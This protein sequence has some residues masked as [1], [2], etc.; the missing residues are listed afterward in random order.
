MRDFACGELHSLAVCNSGEVY[1]WGAGEYGQLGNDSRY[2]RKSPVRVH[3]S[4]DL[5]V[6]KLDAGKNHS[7]ILTDQGFLYCF[8]EDNLGQLGLRRQKKIVE[9]PTIVSYMTHKSVTNVACG[10]FHTVILIDPYYVF[11][12]GNNKY[13]QLGLGDASDKSTFTFVRKLA[14][15][16]VLDVF[17]GDH[18]S[19]FVLDH[20]D[21]FVDDYQMPE[22]WRFSE[23]SVSDDVDFKEGRLRNK[24]KQQEEAALINHFQEAG[25]R[26][27]PD[28]GQKQRRK[29]RDLDMDFGDEPPKRDKRMQMK[30]VEDAQVGGDEPEEVADLHD[31]KDWGGDSDGILES[32]PD[33][34]GEKLFDGEIEDMGQKNFY[35]TKKTFEHFSKDNS[36]V[37]EPPGLGVSKMSGSKQN[38]SGNMLGGPAP[39]KDFS[40]KPNMLGGQTGAVMDLSGNTHLVPRPDSRDRNMLAQNNSMRM[41]P[42]SKVDMKPG[43]GLNMM[44]SREGYNEMGI[45]SSGNQRVPGPLDESDP[46]DSELMSDKGTLMESVEGPNRL[47]YDTK[48]VYP[49]PNEPG[50]KVKRRTVDNP[51]TMKNDLVNTF[52]MINE[53]QAP[54][55]IRHHSQANKNQ[56]RKLY[57]Q[58]EVGAL[59]NSM[60]PS[61]SAL[62]GP[63]EGDFP[64][65]MD[66]AGPF[67]YQKSNQGGPRVNIKRPG[68]GEQERYTEEEE[69]EDWD[70]G[71]GRNRRRQKKQRRRR[72][73]D[74]SEEED[75]YSDDEDGGRRKKKGGRRKGGEDSGDEDSRRK[76]RERSG[77]EGGGDGGAG[78]GAG[79]ENPDRDSAGFF[80]QN[81]FHAGNVPEGMQGQPQLDQRRENY[82][83][84]S[85]DSERGNTMHDQRVVY[86]TYNTYNTY[87]MEKNRGFEGPGGVAMQDRDQR[88]SDERGDREERRNEEDD[89][90]NSKSG[91]EEGGGRGAGE[92]GG[93]RGRGR[94]SPRGP[95][96][97]GFG[98]NQETGRERE[99]EG[100]GGA[101][102]GKGRQTGEVGGGG[103]GNRESGSEEKDYGSEE[104]SGE[105]GDG[106]GGD[107]GRGRRQWNEQ[108][109]PQGPGKRRRKKHPPSGPVQP[110]QTGVAGAHEFEYPADEG[111]AGQGYSTGLNIIKEEDDFPS[112]AQTNPRQSR[113]KMFEEH[114]TR[115]ERRPGGRSRGRQRQGNQNMR[116]V[117]V[118]REEHVEEIGQPESELVFQVVD[119]HVERE[120]VEVRKRRVLTCASRVV[121]TDNKRSH[122]FVVMRILKAE[123]AAV[124]ERIGQYIDLLGERD[125]GMEY[126]NVTDFDNVF[127]PAQQ[128]QLEKVEDLGEY[129]SLTLMMIHN[130][131]E[132]GGLVGGDLRQVDEQYR[133]IRS[134]LTTIGEMYIFTDEELATRRKWQC[135]SQW[136]HLFKDLFKD[137]IHGMSVLE[138]RP[139][140]FK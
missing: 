9:K 85:N 114:S 131:A 60:E 52:K 23:R 126:Y 133:Q 128:F 113:Q 16:N 69:E 77:E 82:G 88:V 90:M 120:R 29:P 117:K 65:G 25:E 81:Q 4:E 21:P 35:P 20:N 64:G 98:G 55:T 96:R 84:G 136:V 54:P 118:R 121:L 42:Q 91:D 132:Y 112:S 75:D 93:D 94:D 123:N 5:K 24:K 8:G 92:A 83:P 40:M 71:P 61:D 1:A 116:T 80:N 49:D 134:Q 17:A 13:G 108:K 124:K 87:N 97:E 7:V 44:G 15:K 62:S 119:E 27:V 63:E 43:S 6:Q 95:P 2:D 56:R 107:G 74:Y 66:S 68:P 89:L 86:N 12:T 76:R 70:E 100:S 105:G 47:E 3:F 32:E 138:L 45:M 110:P 18:H 48:Q 135:L 26:K 111:E 125:P 127:R 34:P 129:T 137:Q 11:T 78:G 102:R 51:M 115:K 33:P 19:W 130:M 99:E 57:S 46:A 103:F 50:Q 41:E 14:H 73:A 140:E 59:G 22:P 37:D 10:T 53:E 109:P 67:G 139:K 101:D 122:R 58:N 79:Q 104:D 36:R 38:L 31:E 30:Y 72:K 39:K 28:S 106:E